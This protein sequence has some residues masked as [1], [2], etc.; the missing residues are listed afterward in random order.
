AKE[1]AAN[2]VN[3]HYFSYERGDSELS[4]E[5]SYQADATLSWDTERWSVQVSPFFNYF[6]NYIYLNPTAT[7]D[8]HYGAG[9]QVFQ[10]AQS[11]VMRYGGEAEVTYR[12]SQQ[13][14]VSF[15]GEYLYAE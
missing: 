14:E 9:N 15:L 7:F 3:Y 5:Q 8:Y 11:R 10:Y 2:G 12:F 6:P 4:P 1:L 13:L